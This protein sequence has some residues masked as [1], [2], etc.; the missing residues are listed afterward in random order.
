MTIDRRTLIGGGIAGGAALGLAAGA[1]RAATLAV[2]ETLKLWPAGPPGGVPAGVKQEETSPLNK[3]G[4]PQLHVAHTTN[5]T[6]TVQRPRKPNGAALLLIPGGGYRFDSLQHEGFDVAAR[7]AQD[8]YTCFSL[9]YRMPA[10]GWQ[11]GPE[12]PLQD[13]QRG[14]RM[15]RSFAS[16]YGYSPDRIGVVGFSAGGHL[17]G[18][19]STRQSVATQA[20]N[21][22]IDREPLSPRATALIYPVITMTGPFGHSGSRIELLGK[23]APEPQRRAYSLDTGIEPTTPPTFLAQAIDD[24]TVPVENSLMMLAAL[25]AAKIPTEAHLFESGGH[26]FGLT[27][28]DGTASPWPDL[29]NTFAKHHGLL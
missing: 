11:A 8:G 4:V 27:L 2:G 23:D 25:R 5:P 16:K 22:A 1:A 10:D 26:G 15:V 19:L 29:F 12:A 24:Q 9:T 28:P 6:L 18:W 3:A 13:A 21:D 20:V 7:F 14:L 17:A